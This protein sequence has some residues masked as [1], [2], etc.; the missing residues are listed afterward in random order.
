[1]PAPTPTLIYRITHHENLPWI[2][3][4]GL[5]CKSHEVQDSCFVTIGNTEIISRRDSRPVKI[6]PGGVLSDY[7]PFYFAPHSMM[8]FQIHTNQVKGCTASQKDIVFLVSSLQILKQQRVPFLFT[9]GHALM[10]NTRYYEA[11]TDL[12][13][14]DWGTIKSKDFR[15]RMDDFDRSRRYQAE[16]LVHRNVHLGAILGIACFDSNCLKVLEE[17]IKCSRESIQVKVKRSWYF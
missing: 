13:A 3:K 4:H 12:S 1:M 10:E 15:K 2:L 9:D 14:L 16:C 7:V 11:S 17:I 5:C 8:L 6:G